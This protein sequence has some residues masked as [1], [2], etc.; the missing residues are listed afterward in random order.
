MVYLEKT[1]VEV[2]RVRTSYGYKSNGPNIYAIDGGFIV[3]VDYPIDRTPLPP[4]VTEATKLKNIESVL[5]RARK[6]GV[7]IWKNRDGAGQDVPGRINYLDY[8]YD[9][10]V[11]HCAWSDGKYLCGSEVPSTSAD[12]SS[13]A[14][15]D[16]TGGVARQKHIQENL[17]LAQYGED[18]D[19]ENLLAHD[20]VSQWTFDVS[21]RGLYDGVGNGF[22]YRQTDFPHIYVAF[23]RVFAQ[24]SLFL[25]PFFS[26]VVVERALVN[27]KDHNKENQKRIVSHL[28]AFFFFPF[29]LFF[30]L[31]FPPS[32]PVSFVAGDAGRQRNVRSRRCSDC[33][34]PSPANGGR[35]ILGQMQQTTQLAVP[36][37]QAVPLS[38]RRE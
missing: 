1:G 25:L 7:D 13:S 12:G 5:L 33:S 18:N 6:E 9:A 8:E 28:H 32:L 29:F 35:Q 17:M 21:Y 27:R 3:E 22:S 15:P 26:V 11:S 24:W 2:H 31:L 16:K 4:A 34:Q 14:N 20:G 19:V 23:V 36:L 38:F 10:A 37:Q 30:S